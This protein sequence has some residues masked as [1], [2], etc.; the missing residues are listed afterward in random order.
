MSGIEPALISAF[1]TTATTMKT[2]Q[3]QNKLGKISAQQQNMRLQQQQAKDG[4]EERRRLD[5]LKQQSASQRARF[6]GLGI[7]GSGGS[8]DAVLEGMRKKSEADAQ[9]RATVNGLANAD[10]GLDAKANLLSQ[11]NAAFQN[12]IDLLI[13]KK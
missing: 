11:K 6:G 9:D 5:L 2:A 10:Q 3:D 12:N 8:A 4:A 1:V 7:G 13:G